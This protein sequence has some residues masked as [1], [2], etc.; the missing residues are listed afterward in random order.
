MSLPTTSRYVLP[1]RQQ[2]L[3]KYLQPHLGSKAELCAICISTSCQPVRFSDPLACKHIFGRAC[4]LEWLHTPSAN[5]C[6]LC[7]RILFK[8]ESPEWS[9]APS[10]SE[11]VVAVTQ[12]ASYFAF[13]VGNESTTQERWTV[14]AQL[15]PPGAGYTD[16]GRWALE[17]IFCVMWH[18]HQE[19]D[20]SLPYFQEAVRWVYGVMDGVGSWDEQP[21]NIKGIFEAWE[22]YQ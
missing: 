3:S 17:K 2:F 16:T 20:A 14:W 21:D 1:S 9:L 6:P 11:L 10:S 19:G 13:R 7:R 22:L 12:L 8:K 4:I 5:T 18:E 15:L